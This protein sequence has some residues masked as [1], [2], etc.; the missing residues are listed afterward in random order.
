V[1]NKCE[2][3]IYNGTNFKMNTRS[4]MTCE[5][6]DLAINKLSKGRVFPIKVKDFISMGVDVADILNEGNKCE[7]HMEPLNH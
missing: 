4:R 7:Y 5:L 1:K 2:K 6:R 3:C